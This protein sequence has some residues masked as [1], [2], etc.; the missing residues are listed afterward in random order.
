[1]AGPKRETKKTHNYNVEGDCGG[2]QKK[3]L[4]EERAGTKKAPGG[5]NNGLPEKYGPGTCRG[6]KR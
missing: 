1:L 5:R 6:K 3:K 2:K 4:E